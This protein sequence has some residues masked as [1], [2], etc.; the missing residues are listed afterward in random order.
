MWLEGLRKI[1][2]SLSSF[3]GQNI[4][5]VALFSGARNYFLR[6]NQEAAFHIQPKNWINYFF[7]LIL[8]A[9]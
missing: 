9:F 5:L 6:P 3:L 4:I 2:K 1:M 7:H 8:S